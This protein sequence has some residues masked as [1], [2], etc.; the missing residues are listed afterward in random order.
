MRINPKLQSRLPQAV[1]P[2]K[3]GRELNNL[4]PYVSAPLQMSGNFAEVS[5][6]SCE[7][8]MEI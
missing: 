7:F 4:C 8:H 5:P 6:Y 2:L 1:R 3:L